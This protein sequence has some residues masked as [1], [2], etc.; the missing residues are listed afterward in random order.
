MLNRRDERPA[1]F[2]ASAPAWLLG[3]PSTYVSRSNPAEHIRSSGLQRVE[4]ITRPRNTVQ[5]R[6]LRSGASPPSCSSTSSDIPAL[7]E[8][9]RLAR[10]NDGCRCERI[11]EI[12]RCCRWNGIQVIAR[13]SWRPTTDK[14]H[15]AFGN[16]PASPEVAHAVLRVVNAPRAAHRQ[17]QIA[18][19]PH[20][21]PSNVLEDYHASIEVSHSARLSI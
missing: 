4:S 17:G 14:R 21:Y 16:W 5:T 9:T 13:R 12:G 20:D 10:I 8:A 18:A 1:D 15:L 3:P 7:W 2:P 19:A 11:A 6:S